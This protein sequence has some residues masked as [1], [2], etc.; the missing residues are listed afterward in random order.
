MS[1][2][3]PE[4]RVTAVRKTSYDMLWHIVYTWGDS[5]KEHVDRVPKAEALRIAKDIWKFNDKKKKKPIDWQPCKGGH[6]AFILSPYA[7]KL[8]KNKA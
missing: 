1:Y 3:Y 7:K 8:M 5:K 4:C 2:K 6:S